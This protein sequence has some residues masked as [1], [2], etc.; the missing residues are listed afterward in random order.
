[1]KKRLLPMA[2]LGVLAGAGGLLTGGCADNDS[3]LFIQ[4]VFFLEAPGCE[5]R[6]EQGA[7]LLAGGGILDVELS[8]TRRYVAPLLI[9]NQIT[10]RG[11]RDQLRTETSRIALK[12]AEVHV[13]SGGGATELTAFTTLADGFVDPG[14]GEDAGYGQIVVTL[15]PAGRDGITMPAP[16]EF[17][18]TLV[19]VRVFGETLGGEE[20]ESNEFRFPVTLCAGCLIFGTTDTNGACLAPADDPPEFAGC[21]LG[22]DFGIHCSQ[23]AG[24]VPACEFPPRP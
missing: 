17:I 7:L 3:I 6:P 14:S 11:S 24:N 8:P 20:V 10:R 12:G 18:D 9:G 22:Q 1:M 19:A 4:G 23:C 21:V 2:V 16:G 13:L 15:I 5:I